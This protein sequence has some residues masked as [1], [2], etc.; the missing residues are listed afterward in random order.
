MVHY[1]IFKAG[2]G[3]VRWKRGKEERTVLHA[4][5]EKKW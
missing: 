2:G 4:E 3:V 1:K 5:K